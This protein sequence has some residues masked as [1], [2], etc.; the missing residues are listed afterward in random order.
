[1]VYVFAIVAI[2][3]GFLITALQ[4]HPDVFF[5]ADGPFGLTKD[6]LVNLQSGGVTFVLD[7]ILIAALL[8]WAISRR[9]RKTVNQTKRWLSLRLRDDLSAIILG[10][11]R[12]PQ[13]SHAQRISALLS[14]SALSLDEQTR[15]AI[16]QFL[17]VFMSYD[18]DPRN[19]YL[20]SKLLSSYSR[21]LNQLNLSK[22]Q[23]HIS[24]DR[25]RVALQFRT[26]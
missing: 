24:E 11:D 20:Q 8:P 4:L 10:I 16:L 25:I 19:R 3:A 5:A 14:Q 17:D 6:F 2:V 21:L 1:L 23:K 12:V 22:L 9:Q 18:H 7:L 15:E 13:A 26:K